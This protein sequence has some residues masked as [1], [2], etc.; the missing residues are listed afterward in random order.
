MESVR[1]AIKNS[2]DDQ[3]FWL[4]LSSLRLSSNRGAGKGSRH[5]SVASKIKLR[6]L[7]YILSMMSGTTNKAMDVEYPERL[8]TKRSKIVFFWVPRNS[9]ITL[10]RVE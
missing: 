5:Y 10:F 2:N 9:P 3:A 8:N 1:H 4:S 6:L 7:N